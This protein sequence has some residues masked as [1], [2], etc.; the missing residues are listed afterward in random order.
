MNLERAREI[1]S[2]PT[3]VNVIHNGSP[4]YIE[5]VVGDNSAYVHPLN[6]PKNSQK[7]SVSSLI[8]Q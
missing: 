6:Q 8:E 7:V 1:A 5:S 4:V 3:M 2:S